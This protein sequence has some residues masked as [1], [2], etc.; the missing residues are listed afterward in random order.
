MKKAEITRLTILEQAFDLI[1]T[2]GYQTTSIDDILAKTKVTKGAFYYHF[3][4]KDEMGIAIIQELIKPNFEHYFIKPLLQ[5]K[6]PSTIL[7]QMMHDALLKNEF[8]KVEYGCPASNLTTEMAPWNTNFTKVLNEL[9]L[10]WKMCLEICLQK[11]IEQNLIRK[12]IDT[13]QVAIFIMS[14]YWGIRNLGKLVNS[15]KVY[16]DYLKQFEAYLNLLK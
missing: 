8:L 4:N 2:K 11:G 7:Y 14:G 1:Y 6:D 15:T 5:E 10:K 9:A 16:K 12:D 3:K 13:E